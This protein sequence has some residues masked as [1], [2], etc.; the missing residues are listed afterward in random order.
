MDKNSTR[1]TEPGARKQTSNIK[2]SS[3][4]LL[5]TSCTRS[6]IKFPEKPSRS[7][8]F[9]RHERSNNQTR[10]REKKKKNDP[11]GACKLTHIHTHVR[12]RLARGIKKNPG[13]SGA[14]RE[15]FIRAAALLSFFL[16]FFFYFASSGRTN[17]SG[18]AIGITA[19]GDRAAALWPMY[20]FLFVLRALFFFCSFLFSGFFGA[21]DWRVPR[22]RF[23]LALFTN[24][25]VVC[26]C[27]CVS[28]VK[29]EI[30]GEWVRFCSVG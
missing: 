14:R 8:Y 10:K 11:F 19:P 20:F 26:A 2:A 9:V 12:A 24:G 17:C 15:Q 21:R 3:R 29:I 1:Y 30:T 7:S 27:V 5:Y 22:A 16:I 13:R 4:R 6:Q 28:A 23:S 25:S 18:G